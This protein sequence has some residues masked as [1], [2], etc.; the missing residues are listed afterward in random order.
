MN[1]PQSSMNACYACVNALLR[2]KI[3]DGGVNRHETGASTFMYL[4][5]EGWLTQ[6]KSINH[7][8][9]HVLSLFAVLSFKY[10]ISWKSQGV[11]VVTAMT[12]NNKKFTPVCSVLCSVP[13]RTATIL[14]LF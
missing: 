9:F 2:T 3:K 11:S 14:R 12:I 10:N 5:Q 6:E 8:K 1:S 13:I 4:C 7:W